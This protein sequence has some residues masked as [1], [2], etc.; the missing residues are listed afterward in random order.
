MS[1]TIKGIYHNGVIKP[2]DKVKL[3]DGT[4][5]TM[6]MTIDAE[7]SER[8]QR[9]KSQLELLNRLKAKG[10]IKDI[11]QKGLEK[12]TPFLPIKVKGKPVSQ[13]IIADRDRG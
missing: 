7:G 12:M 11:P 3:K 4:V 1:R 10:L 2:L 5:I 6:T 13:T 8:S 9:A